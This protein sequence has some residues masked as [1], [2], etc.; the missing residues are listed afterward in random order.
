MFSSIKKYIIGFFVLCGGLL[1]AFLTGKSAGKK[2]EKVKNVKK[3]IKKTKKAINTKKKKIS[4][5][6]KKT[7]KKK[8]VGTKEAAD[9]LKKFAK[10]KKK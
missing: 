2:N 1:M 10:G 4:N 9:Y 3:N 6:K 5:V 7:Y 8:N